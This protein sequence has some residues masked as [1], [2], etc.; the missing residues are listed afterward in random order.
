MNESSKTLCVGFD[1]HKDSVAVA[2]APEARPR[3]WAAPVSE[4]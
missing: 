4:A 2:Y 1:V 3:C